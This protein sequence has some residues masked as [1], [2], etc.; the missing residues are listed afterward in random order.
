LLDALRAKTQSF[1]YVARQVD[2]ATAQAVLSLKLAGVD[3]YREDTRV[4]PGGDL[5]RGVI[6]RT[7]IDGKGIAG[8]ELQYNT[9]LTGTDGERVTEHDTKGNA[10][11]GSGGVSVPAVPGNDLVLTLDRS[12]QFTLEQALLAQVS[13]LGAKGGTA[14]VEQSAT[15]N[16]L[17]M[18][19]VR[20]DEHDQYHVTSVNIATVDCY[21][22]GSVAKVVTAS[23]AIN[24]GLVTP[25]T[26]FDVPYYRIFDKGTPWEHTIRDAEPHPVESMSVRDILV[27][28]S[29]MGTIMESEK[30]GPQ[31]QWEYMDA[32]GL[33]KRSD[34]GFPGES[35]G[36]LKNW[37][38][39]QGTERITPSYGY[40]VCV[41]AI[42]L[43]GAVN[44]VANGGVYV[45]PRLVQA[46]IGNDGTMTDAP[47]AAT[48]DVITPQ[49]AATMNDLMRSVVCDGT[50]T[51]AQVDGITIAGKT[52]TGVKSVNGKYGVEGKDAAYYSSFV[53]FFPAEKP[54]VTTL[55]SIDEPPG[56]D[57]GH[58]GGTAA[59]PV[60][61]AVVPTIM[62]Q[63]GVQPPTTTGGCPKT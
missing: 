18:A 48:H 49:T 35:K 32:F 43:V 21:E 5:A 46:T 40:G 56:G 58:F 26:Y 14:I 10:I 41:P 25:D 7:D 52:G 9:L 59:A 15:G 29:N 4:V 31:R 44:V 63:L 47:P 62:H 12:I 17:A 45:A 61:K 2:E 54:A 6:G 60:F 36:I 3:S 16:I 42:Q 37:K 24:D 19:S 57:L 53:G 34:L 8:L 30:L 1:V 39:W 20:R 13:S 11:P 50:A 33:G 27:K 28:S 22:P 55:V 23:A 38:D 51:R